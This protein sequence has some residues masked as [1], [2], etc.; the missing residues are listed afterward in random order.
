MG[1]YP[2]LTSRNA[3]STPLIRGT[4]ANLRFYDFFQNLEVGWQTHIFAPSHTFN[5]EGT[6]YHIICPYQSNVPFL[7]GQKQVGKLSSDKCS[8]WA[9]LDKL[10]HTASF[11]P[12]TKINQRPALNAPADAVTVVQQNGWMNSDIFVTCLKVFFFFFFH[13]E[14]IFFVCF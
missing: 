8:V 7:R 1:R 3:Q 6:W 4:A 10:F 9:P 14:K 11:S 13:R 5:P 12:R 2:Q